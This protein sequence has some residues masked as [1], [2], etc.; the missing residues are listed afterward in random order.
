MGQY[1]VKL[2]EKRL[3]ARKKLTG[4]M[5]GKFQ[6]EGKDVSARPVDISNHG[7]GILVAKEFKTGSLAT[8]QMK[9]KK[10][11]LKIMWSQQDFGKNDMW[12]YGLGTLDGQDDLEKIF[13]SSGCLK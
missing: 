4:L 10:I 1:Q 6:I 3:S 7:L 2:K 11:E 9:D 13:E 12:R 8:L 5:P